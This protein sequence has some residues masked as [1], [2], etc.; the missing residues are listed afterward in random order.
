MADLSFGTKFS[1]WIRWW[2][3]LHCQNCGNRTEMDGGKPLDIEFR[4]LELEQDGVWSVS[5]TAIPPDQ[6]RY[7]SILRTYF[8]LDIA[9][10]RRL[11]ADIAAGTFR[12]LKAEAAEVAD[13]V[14]RAGGTAT[15]RRAD[16]TG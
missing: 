16:P 10:G 14:R 13:V 4:R 8:E 7:L 2:G 9:G 15:V 11:R 12:G 1:D 5:L 3:S 6:V